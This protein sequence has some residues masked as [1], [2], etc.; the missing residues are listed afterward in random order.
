LLFVVIP[1]QALSRLHILSLSA[2]LP[3]S[4]VIEGVVEASDMHESDERAWAERVFGS[5][6]LGD[7]RRVDRLIEVAALLA[8]D[9]SASMTKACKGDKAANEGAQRLIRNVAVDPTDIDDAVFESTASECQ[10]NCCVLVI[11]D[12]T[13]IAIKNSRLAQ[14]DDI[15]SSDGFQVHTAFAV[16]AKMGVPIGLLDQVRWMRDPAR[17][18]KSK[19]K[20]KRRPYEQKE[21]FK[22]EAAHSRIMQLTH[23]Q[24]NLI[25]V[26]DREADVFEYLAFMIDHQQRFIQRAT[27]NRALK[28]GHGD[29][30]SAVAELQS[31]SEHSVA[32]QQRG[33]VVS[34]HLR[35]HRPGRKDRLAVVENRAACVTVKRPVDR[36]ELPESLTFNAVWV[37]EPKPPK[38]QKP[39]DWLLLTSEPIDTPEQ[40]ST[41]IRCYE[42]RWI[43]EQFHQVWKTGCR[44]EE[45]LLDDLDRYERLYAITAPIAVRLLQ[46][47]SLQNIAPE[48]SCEAVLTPEEWRCLHAITT[49]S[50]PLPNRAPTVDWAVRRI[51]KLGGW[52]DSKRTGRIGWTTMWDGWKQFQQ[53]FRGWHA[54]L[55]STGKPP[56]LA[57]RLP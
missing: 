37:H 34:G 14:R 27:Y 9:P 1:A 38:G 3:L 25:F 50:A 18:T 30:R 7:I 19:R 45:R 35:A 8:V 56:P 16:D 15:G 55:T 48:M 51:A 31:V 52:L 11:Q 53:Q 46:L 12:T 29:I 49:P 6:E 17:V 13:S 26:A 57:A 22:W 43:I 41:I 36:P 28:G 32:I 4:V 54:A 33:P 2:S 21:S 40:V 44:I 42:K 10:G 39:L 24:E 20:S 47:R 23:S 5:A